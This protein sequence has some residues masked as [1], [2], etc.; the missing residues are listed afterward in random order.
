MPQSKRRAAEAKAAAAVAKAARAEEPKGTAGV[1][2][3]VAVVAVV[4]VA[5]GAGAWTKR[6]GGGNGWLG[7]RVAGEAEAAADTTEGRMVAGA[8]EG[9]K[10]VAAG[11]G[12]AGVTIN[13]QDSNDGEVKMCRHT[14]R[15]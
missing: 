6:S 14:R 11:A 12:A 7:H 15:G 9:S 2:V 4:A 3:V 1:V 8:P 10:A 5:A 13:S